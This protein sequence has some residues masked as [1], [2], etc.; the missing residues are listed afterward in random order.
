MKFEQ[1]NQQLFEQISSED[2]GKINGGAAAEMFISLT[3]IRNTVI[4]ATRVGKQADPV[5]A[6]DV[7]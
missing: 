2:L 7:D 3:D 5:D 6:G 4:I 1:L